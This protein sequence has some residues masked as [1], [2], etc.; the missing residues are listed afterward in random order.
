MGTE[1]KKMFKTLSETKLSKKK[2]KN[3]RTQYNNNL[4]AILDREILDRLWY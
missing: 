2:K 4:P 1:K 3:L